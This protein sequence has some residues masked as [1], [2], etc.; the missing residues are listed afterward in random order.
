MRVLRLALSDI[1]FK[2]ALTEVKRRGGSAE[3]AGENTENL[4]GAREGRAGWLGLRGKERKTLGHGRS[5]YKQ[6][7]KNWTKPFLGYTTRVVVVLD[8]LQVGAYQ[9]LAQVFG[10]D[11]A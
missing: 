8:R 2:K 10:A 1:F 11:A 5:E 3:D 4:T 6:K 9:D 7:L